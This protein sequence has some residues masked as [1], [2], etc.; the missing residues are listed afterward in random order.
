MDF[1]YAEEQ[2]L[3]VDALERYLSAQYKFA[4]R[5][6][7]ACGPL[8]Y[9]PQ[10]WGELVELGA[11]GALFAA[12]AGGYGGGPFD[13]QLVFQSLG[14]WLVVEPFLDT[15]MV[16]HA[17]L[18]AG[19]A[20]RAAEVVD[21]SLM[22]AL[23]HDEPGSHYEPTLVGTR[24]RRSGDGWLLTGAKTVVRNAEHAGALL[25]SARSSGKPGD[26][27]GITLFLVPRQVRGVRVRGYPRIDG[28]RAGEVALDD[29]QVPD[30]DRVG[31][32]GGGAAVLEGAVD[33]GVLALCSEALGLME[34]AQRSTVEYLRTRRQFGVPIGSFQALQHRMVDVFIGID[35]A[36]SAVINAAAAMTGPLQQRQLALAAAKVSIGRIGTRVA[37]EC[38]QMHGG[39]GM[40]WE[41]PLAHY[42]KRLVMIDHELGDQDH[43][44]NRYL[45]L[46]RRDGWRALGR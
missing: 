31:E 8:G 21:G 19:D 37:E 33:W 46:R 10:R 38:I 12:D 35:Q 36:R 6:A 39:I 43:H 45:E 18:A 22:P 2:R 44:L 23:A 9:D 11:V 28:G 32:A 29:V 26:R 13:V 1:E 15:L 24:A 16:G 25:V 20:E 30:A 40:T 4:E 3:L 17:L 14:H 27:D 7:S 42:A 5:Q 41:L 34:I